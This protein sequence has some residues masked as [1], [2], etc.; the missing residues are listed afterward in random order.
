MES[1]IAPALSRFAMHATHPEA[2]FNNNNN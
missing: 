1:H 2:V